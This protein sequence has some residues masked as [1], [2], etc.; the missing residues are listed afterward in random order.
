MQPEG[1][2]Q[3]GATKKLCHLDVNVAHQ[4]YVSHKKICFGNKKN[5]LTPKRR[6]MLT[7]YVQC[8]PGKGYIFTKNG[9]CR[10]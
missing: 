8:C 3:Y 5:Q 9:S 4:N 7:K 6:P 2:E 10:I 1:G